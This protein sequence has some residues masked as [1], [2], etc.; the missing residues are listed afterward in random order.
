M[1]AHFT[2][3]DLHCTMHIFHSGG[4]YLYARIVDPNTRSL[5]PDPEF[6]PNLDHDTNTNPDPRATY[7]SSF[8]WLN[9]QF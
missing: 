3:K 5:D 7:E 4:A 6:C 9:D 8:T 1:N 2:K